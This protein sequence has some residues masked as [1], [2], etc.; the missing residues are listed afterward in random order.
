MA[1]LVDAL[2]SG[3][4][5]Q[6]AC[7]GSSP[8][9]R[10]PVGLMRYT[11]KLVLALAIM[12]TL[13]LGGCTT[14]GEAEINELTVHVSEMTELL[15]RHKDKPELALD[16]LEQYEAEHRE[17]LEDLNHRIKDLRPQLT[18]SEKRTLSA[19]WKKQTAVL[20]G[21]LRELNKATSSD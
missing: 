2:D 4:S 10:S 20:E 13:S 16:A 7:G 14:R 6:Y 21:K 9:F 11:L 17:E 1:E 3:S 8:P 12:G 5:G 18:S 19:K 15:D